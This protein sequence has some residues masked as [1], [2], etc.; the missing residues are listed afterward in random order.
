MPKAFRICMGKKG[1]RIRT[2][3]TSTSTY[4]HVC[5]APGD[6]G[7]TRGEIKRRLAARQRAHSAGGGQLRRRN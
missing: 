1:R 7:W 4:M 3:R 5:R 2:I 6:A